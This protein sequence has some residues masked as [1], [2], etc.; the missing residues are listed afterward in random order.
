MPDMNGN[1]YPWEEEILAQKQDTAQGPVPDVALQDPDIN[2]PQSGYASMDELVNSVA[3]PVN[4]PAPAPIVN[5]PVTGS[6]GGGQSSSSSYSGTD[7]SNGGLF[8]QTQTKGMTGY[9]KYMAEGH[10]RAAAYANS[11]NA[12]RSENIQA[13][14]DAATE[15]AN[16][17]MQRADQNAQNTFDL[18]AEEK[19]MAVDN[20][21]TY[22]NI[23]TRV[24]GKMAE[25]ETSVNE[26]AAMGV[27]P[28]KAYSNLTSAQQ[29]GVLVTAFVTDFLGAKGI[30]TSGM[31]Y[32]NQAIERNIQAQRDEINL[33][34][35]V[36]QGKMN[37][38]RM[39]KEQGDS[40]MLAAEKT[41]GAL[42]NAFKTEAVG[43]LLTFDS[44]LARGKAMQV[45]ALLTEKGLEQKAGVAK[46]YMDQYNQEANQ[47]A[48]LRG[49]DLSAAA[50]RASVAES[51][52]QFNATRADAKN[53]AVP[54]D[55]KWVMTDGDGAPIGT[56][57]EKDNYE[58]VADRIHN[59][60]ILGKELKELSD[61]VSVTKKTYKGP[62][63]HMAKD[64][65][66]AKVEARLQRLAFA[67][68]R[69]MN[70]PGVLTEKDVENARKVINTPGFTDGLLSGKDP[71]KSAIEV[72]GQAGLGTYQ[73]YDTFAKTRIRPMTPEQIAAFGRGGASP[74]SMQSA[75]A[76]R[77]DA[78]IKDRGDFGNPT[79]DASDIAG[80]K[81]VAEG[82]KTSQEIDVSD[83]S[84]ERQYEALYEAI[85]DGA[86]SG[87]RI[88][89]P[90]TDASFPA[91]VK[92][93]KK[94]GKVP[95]WLPEMDNLYLQ[96]LD[97]SGTQESRNKAAAILT[98]LAGV[99][100]D[101]SAGQI[102]R[103]GGF[104]MSDQ[105]QKR[106]VALYYLVKMGE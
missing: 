17:E 27:N 25:Y 72:L 67:Y 13:Q 89:V 75:Q 55:G 97:S 7:F 16:V 44:P 90:G 94:Y 22:A 32:I 47:A 101:N 83:V 82:K 76:L 86:V 69:S 93:Y 23:Q 39:F 100:E 1:L 52:R 56:I 105:D 41:R 74:G 60:E 5:T 40:D 81:V 49:Q 88:D 34:K 66:H 18:A 2:P 77:D 29:G 98:E 104:D 73:D 43:K 103:S 11:L 87:E 46:A 30:K 31:E 3:G 99:G 68:A 78:T 61:D 36:V 85:K 48:Q 70:G 64:A 9:K 59:Y 53:A 14:K 63:A 62:L 57:S 65:L 79:K 71:T 26:L 80:G 102:L 95:A 15:I 106:A 92:N 35:D 54:F 28:G 51:A 20:A 91:T 21:A 10:N 19:K 8:D 84:G 4:T 38:Y 45:D 96:A 50:S 12:G 33:K 24:A 42:F 6:T 37:I 58:H